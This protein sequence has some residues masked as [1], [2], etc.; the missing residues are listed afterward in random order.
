MRRS[1]PCHAC[2]GE[3]L[4]APLGPANS[5]HCPVDSHDRLR[6]PTLARIGMYDPSYTACASSTLWRVHGLSSPPAC[7][8][9]PLML[10]VFLPELFS[11]CRSESVLV[12]QAAS[13]VLACKCRSLQLPAEAIP[14]CHDAQMHSL[15][16]TRTCP[17]RGSVLHAHAH[18]HYMHTEGPG[19]T[20]I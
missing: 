7:A 3:R 13:L 20:A 19:A 16:Y 9:P 8:P 1:R 11:D 18:A 4:Q 5:L 10:C 14:T 6:S 15:R 17:S 2:P 12:L